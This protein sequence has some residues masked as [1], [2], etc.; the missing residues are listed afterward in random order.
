MWK[1]RPAVLSAFLA[2][3]LLLGAA[4]ALAHH[5]GPVHLSFYG[6][7]GWGYP[8]YSYWGVLPLSRSSAY[9][10]PGQPPEFAVV[11]TDVSPERARVVLDGEDIGKADNFDGFPDYLYLTPGERT[12]EFR[13]EGYRALLVR[14]TAG[15][16]MYYGIDRSLARLEKGKPV[17]G[18]EVEV[19]PPAPARQARQARPGL[20]RGLRLRWVRGSAERPRRIPWPERSPGDRRTASGA[21]PA[22]SAA[23]SATEPV[24]SA[25]ASAT[26]SAGS[27]AARNRAFRPARAE[28]GDASGMASVLFRLRPADA[29]VYLGR[30]A[31]GRGRHAGRRGQP[32]ARGRPASRGGGEARLP[33]APDRGPSARGRVADPDDRARPRPGGSLRCGLARIS[34]RVH[35]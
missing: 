10:Y 26:E 21:E 14:L 11:D 28:P 17:P 29:A 23:A 31:R 13:A 35:G 8:W 32:Q 4:P 24:G 30:K 5:S 2:S 33:S 20:K 25:E 27:A 3:I 9:P 15:R 6:G 34:H 18:P 12:I 7:F 16:G 19:A 1:T 22:G